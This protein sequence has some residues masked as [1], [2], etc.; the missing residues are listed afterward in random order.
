M[1]AAVFEGNGRLVL[2]ERPEPKIKKPTDVLLKVQGVGICGTDL[3]ILQVPPA[4]PARLGIIQGHEFTGEVVAVGSAAGEFAPGDQVLVDPH[5]GCGQ[6][7]QCRNGFPDQCT[8][9]ISASGEP[10]HPGTI[11]IFSDGGFAP[12]AIV[13]LNGLY[14]LRTRVPT[15]LAALAEPLACVLHSAGKLGVKPGDSVVVLGAGPIGCLFTAVLK[16]AGAARLIVSEPSAFRRERAVRCGATRVV[17]PT[18]EDLDKVVAEETGAGADVV[19]EAVGP[20]IVTAMRLAR[21]AGT[22]L[23]FGHDELAEPKIPM[24][25]I[26]K[27]ELTIYGGFIGRFSFQRVAR[28]LESGQLPLDVVVTHRIPL[29]DVHK[30]LD[31]L[32]KQLALKVVVEP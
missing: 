25:D 19:V 30:G 24:K 15:H 10:G 2:T 28:I 17:D 32:R 22:V 13:P 21:F 3:H 26:I 11:G 8:T 16:A 18:K 7:A 1:Q 29:A 14:K 6:C 12:Y 20:L 27:K 9:L 5:P 4:H 31:L 23:Q